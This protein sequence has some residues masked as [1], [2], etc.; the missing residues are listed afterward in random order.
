[1]APKE[2]EL[3]DRYFN[4]L[5][6]ELKTIRNLAVFG[7]NESISLEKIYVPL[8]FR[9]NIREEESPLNGEI[10]GYVKKDAHTQREPVQIDNE[11]DVDR[12]LRKYRHLMVT[13]PPGAGKSTMVQYLALKICKE[14][15]TSPEGYSIPVLITLREFIQGKKGLRDHINEIFERCGIRRAKKFIEKNLNQGRC[16][17]FLDGFDELFTTRERDRVVREI[18]KFLKNYPKCPVL[19]TSRV[20]AYPE[21]LSGFTRLEL[22]EFDNKQINRFIDRWFGPANRGKADTV[23]RLV[24]KNKDI[25]AFARNPLMLAI[26]TAFYDQDYDM[27]QKR[28]NLY[29]RITDVFLNEWD[30]QKKIG[31][32]FSPSIKKYILRKLAYRNHSRQRQS[33]TEKEILEEIERQA[34]PPGFETEQSRSILEEIGQR[35]YIF[36][37]L[38][39]SAYDFLHMSFQEYFTALELAE[40]EDGLDTFHLHLSDPWWEEPI[41]LYAGIKRDAGPL[42]NMIRKKKPEDIF[43]SNLLLAGKCIAEAEYTDL[44]LK[45]KITRELWHLVNSGDFQL[46]KE[47]AIAVLA[48]LQP[49]FIIDELVNRLTDKELGVRRFAA[50]TLGL[51]GNAD[52]LPALLMTLAKDTDSKIRG[53]AAAALGEIGS[54]E[55]V[56]PLIRVL[57]SDKE[58]N[59][60]RSAAAALGAIGSDEALPALFKTLVKDPDSLV[61]G[62]GAEAIGKIE[63]PESIPRI[64]QALSTE[65]ESSVR[66]RT[67]LTLGKLCGSDAHDLLIETLSNDKDKEVRESAAESLG[68]IGSAEGTTALIKALSFDSN[69]DVRGSAAYALGQIKSKEALPALIRTLISDI[70]GEVRGRAAFALG[71]LKNTAAIPYLAAIFNTHKKSMIR[72]NAAFALGEIGG[73][74]AIPFLIQALTIDKDSYV[75]Y[76]AAEVLGSIGNVV[77][78]QP[79][80]IALEDEGSYYGWRVKD[81]AYEAL[82]KISK[83]FHVRITPTRNKGE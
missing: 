36:R 39:K 73:G 38:F 27:R 34:F 20:T 43:Y 12:A 54:T 57:G 56:Q 82:E 1:V 45:E 7:H 3:F 14:N 33:L 6:D 25:E 63:S 24:T 18:R 65:K 53:Q 2:Y 64:I 35:S 42:I 15:I 28:C 46:L 51:I 22:A 19:I 23:I 17:L 4:A 79:L 75:R 37:Q 32:R 40:H 83:R 66:W 26:I 60:R 74:E 61:R 69:A 10:P 58:G 52:V 81:K 59:V 68:H 16:F 77:T 44:F 76:R 31:N 47:R 9:K 48:R 41:L 70:N 8:K 50:D 72:G 80:K 71:R 62:G 67:A 78:L 49:R 11:A 13:G 30:A 21:E 29:K 55:A 5:K